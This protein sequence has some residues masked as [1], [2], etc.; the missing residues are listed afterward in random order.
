VFRR[1]IIFIGLLGGAS[2]LHAQASPT[3]SRV[4]DLKI[5]GGFTNANTDYVPNR[6]NGG[7]AYFD[8]DFTHHFGLEGEFHFVKD[9]TGTQVYEKTYE[10]GGRYYRTYGRLVPYGKIMIGRGVFN[11]PVD[12]AG[13]TTANLAYN[14]FAGGVGAD[15]KLLPYLYVRG[16]FEYQKWSS[17]PPDG[18]SPS[19]V[20]IGVAY[21]F[22]GTSKRQ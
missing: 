13:N 3:A 1:S 15:Y 4:A 19:L 9:T 14:M 22:R 20:S 5:G 16:D 7:M 18:L 2:L 11:F 10:I 17:F 8:F 12:S 21:H 6:V